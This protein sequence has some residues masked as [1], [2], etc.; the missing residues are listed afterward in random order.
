MSVV[1]ITGSGGLIGSQAARHFS[2][3]GLH[4]VGIDNDMRRFFF[5]PE[6][7]VQTNLDQLAADLGGGYSHVPVDVRDRDTVDG[8]LRRY[9]RDVSLVVHAASQPAHDSQS[10]LIDWDINATGTANMLDA[11]RRHASGAVFVFLSTIKVYGQEPN[12]LHYQE[13]D[14]RYE[15]PP[16]SPWHRGFDESMSI[17]GGAHSVFGASKTAA[18]IFAQE[19]GRYLDLQTVILRGGCL[20]GPAHAAVEAH[21][22]LAYLM[23][24]VMT[25]RPYRILGTGKQVRDNIH[26]VDVA[27]AIE[28]VWHDPPW[29]GA[30]FNLGGGRGR[31]VSI[32]EALAM[33]KAI[34]EVDPV[35]EHAEERRGDHKWWITDM[36]RFEARYPDWFQTYDVPMILKEIYTTNADR[37]RP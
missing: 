6:G 29:P 3:L 13:T 35:V 10:P 34:T 30:V 7:S 36:G 25:G 1:I 15:R 4:V 8:L 26:T 22:F 37:W 28:R 5:G 18:D 31:D 17:D 20:T 33:A 2:A 16:G 12:E 21:G 24:C 9:G 19:Y 27:R 32:I 11:T 23:K 14:T